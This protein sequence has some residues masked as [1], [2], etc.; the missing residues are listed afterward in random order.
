VHGVVF[1]GMG[2]PL[3]NLPEVLRTLPL[4]SEPSTLAIDARNVT[5]CT[6]GL[7]VPLAQL[8]SA[9]P[10]MR[11]GLS[12]GSALTEKRRRLMPIERTQP[13]TRS[14]AVLADHARHTGIAPLLSYTLLG[15]SNDTPADLA[16]F[17]SLLMAFVERATL[18]PR[19]SL[20]TY[21]P[22]GEGDRFAPAAPDRLEAFRVAI[23]GLGIP[24]VRRYSGGA[25]V[26][27][28][29]GQLGCR[30]QTLGDRHRVD[31]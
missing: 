22:L 15:G 6:A 14:L 30:Y 19:V 17:V 2:E 11:V 27:A 10:R 23:G 20:G 12:I 5:V 29:C 25:D 8:V 18:A 21:N 3:L 9:A 7:A 1:Q 4:L 28:A 31:R 13:L 24:V 16:A 26:G